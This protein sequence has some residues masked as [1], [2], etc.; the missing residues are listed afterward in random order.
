MLTQ[1]HHQCPCYYIMNDMLECYLWASN[2]Q[3]FDYCRAHHVYDVASQPRTS[4]RFSQWKALCLFA[5][6][7]WRCSIQPEI[8]THQNFLPEPGFDLG[9]TAGEY[10][11]LT[12]R[13][14]MLYFS[15][16]MILDKFNSKAFIFFSY[17]F[18]YNSFLI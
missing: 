18:F 1:C 17:F 14:H 5:H 4:D 3:L 12:A 11:V 2:H 15:M 7:N 9:L 16:F 10:S 8:F 6:D 13:L